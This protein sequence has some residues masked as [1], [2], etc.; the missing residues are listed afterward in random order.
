MP[1]KTNS[2]TLVSESDLGCKPP[3]Y[4]NLG[5]QSDASEVR[6]CRPP[7]NFDKSS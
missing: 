3:T 7:L 2:E 4:A 5:L 1:V 6:L